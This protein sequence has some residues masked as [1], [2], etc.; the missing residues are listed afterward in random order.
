MAINEEN[1]EHIRRILA[2]GEFGSPDDVIA[3]A[4][5]LLDEHKEELKRELADMRAKVQEGIDQLARGEYTE[6]TE[7]TLHELFEDVKR[8]GRGRRGAPDNARPG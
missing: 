7:E 4:L 3:Q 1:Q 8:R 5:E 6:Y 2:S